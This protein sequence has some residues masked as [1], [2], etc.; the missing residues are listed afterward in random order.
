MAYSPQRTQVSVL[1]TSKYGDK[2]TVH[3][4]SPPSIS[5]FW[6]LTKP[7]GY[8]HICNVRSICLP[9]LG[10]SQ[11]SYDSYSISYPIPRSSAYE[12]SQSKI[13][14]SGSTSNISPHES[15][16]IKSVSP[17]WSLFICRSWTFRSRTSF[18]APNFPSNSKTG[19]SGW[20]VFS[21]YSMNFEVW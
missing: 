18:A 2:S 5:T 6:L 15:Q 10:H 1:S 4:I 16:R 12:L 8:S 14:S 11:V 9:Q 19:S 21:I 20:Y 17:E 13:K 3:S 7:I